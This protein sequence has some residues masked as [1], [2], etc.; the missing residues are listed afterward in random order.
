[1]RNIL[2]TGGAGY[3]GSHTVVELAAAGFNPVIVDNLVN[4][5]KKII[6]RLEKL[7]GKKISFYENSCHDRTALKKIIKNQKIDGAIHFAAFK[8]PGE[9]VERPLLY[10]QNNVGELI[11]LLEV[12]E[13]TKV[14]NLVFSSSC[15]VYGQ[16]N[17]PPLTENSPLRPP[18]APYGASK[19]MGETI[20][21]D[22]LSVAKNLRGLALRYFNPIG[23]HPSALIGELPVQDVTTLVPHINLAAAG[24]SD[25]L[26]V[27]GNDYP[28]KDG[29]CIR[30]FIH[31]VDLARAHIA[32]LKFLSKQKPRYFDIFNIGTGKGVT[33]LE[34]IKT[35]EKVNGVKVPY[36]IGSR[37]PGDIVVSYANA[38]K[39]KK[40]LGW[41]T[42]KSLAD[43]LADAWRWQQ[44]LN[45]IKKI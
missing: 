2:V 22:A 15:V 8:A 25:G 1:M 23:A 17:K 36:K 3:I 19:Q 31:V 43:G 33:I 13:E 30:D 10:Y 45:K 21:K 35:F 18:A 16:P 27:F 11:D 26:V 32:A 12:I 20:L 9:S 39:T 7:T 28:T 44:A 34:T 40:V 5:D 37:R 42:E 6:S 29:T 14:P 24:L 4:S 41:Q 38:D